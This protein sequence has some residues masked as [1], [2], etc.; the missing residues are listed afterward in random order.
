MA[1]LILSKKEKAAA[2]WT[3]LDDASLGRLVKKKMAMVISAA[4]QLD[5]STTFAAT[6]LLCC[7]AAEQRASEL[8]LDI[9]GVTQ[10]GREFGDWSVVV[11]KK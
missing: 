10:D 2:L 4:E 9:D 8:V 6:L 7:A 5:R 3:D 11:T 1:E